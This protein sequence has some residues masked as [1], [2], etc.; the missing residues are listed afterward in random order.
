[1][2]LFEVRLPV[3]MP[4]RPSQCQSDSPRRSI[5]AYPRQRKGRDFSNFPPRRISSSL[6]PCGY[7]PQV[8]SATVTN[9]AICRLSVL[10]ILVL[11]CLYNPPFGHFTRLR[12]LWFCG[13]SVTSGR[14]RLSLPIAESPLDSANG[15]PHPLLSLLPSEAAFSVMLVLSQTITM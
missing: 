10:L 5:F 12:C 15:S 11:P 4:H 1:M 13:S 6:F 8:P 3:Q 9:R 14:T 7:S 2:P